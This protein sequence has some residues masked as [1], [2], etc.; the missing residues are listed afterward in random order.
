[1]AATKLTM[2]SDPNQG[3]LMLIQEHLTRLSPTQLADVFQF[4]RFLEFQGGDSEDTDLWQAVV[5]NE[6]YKA[7]HLHEG[8]DRYETV[9]ALEAALAEL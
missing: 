9:E 4:V 6:Q 5:A 1:M 2:Q 3:I 8:L 7:L